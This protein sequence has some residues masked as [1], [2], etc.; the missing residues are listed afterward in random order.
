MQLY[1]VVTLYAHINLFIAENCAVLG[2]YAAN[3]ADSLP[4]FQDNLSVHLRG[5]RIQFLIFEAGRWY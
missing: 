1:L 2:Y 3:D 5:S 4:A